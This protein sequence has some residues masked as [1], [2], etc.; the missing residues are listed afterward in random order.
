MTFAEVKR[1][2]E[3]ETAVPPDKQRLLCNGKER[4]DDK[5]TLAAAGVG[6]KSKLMLM[7]VPGY[8]MP[9]PPAQST[10]GE[11]QAA[12]AAAA[13]AAAA[14]GTETVDEG[15]QEPVILEGVLG[16]P[17]DLAD[18]AIAGSVLVRQ[19]PNRFRI[20]LTKGLHEVTFGDIADYLAAQ[21]LPPGIP[22]SELRL[23][24][25][26]KTASREDVL[27]KS[28]SNKECSILLLFREG[29]HLAEEGTR[30][31]REQAEELTQAEAKISSL[32]KRVEA[33]FCDAET[34]LQLAEVAGRV[35]TF[36]QSVESVRVNATKLP[37][38]EELRDRARKA[39]ER[40]QAL[41]KA[42]RF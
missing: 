31:M 13:A 42:V 10:Q 14:P 12:G 41:R 15:S 23:I 27:D 6:A 9:P 40:L 26:G 1:H 11:A 29:F 25:K 18:E 37:A 36:L 8:A 21:M 19:G 22:A 39:H 20:R 24:S 5:E 38:M 2:I 34:S 32:A 35:E 7:L 33:N 4:K 3:A 17:Q 16:G 28:G 30:W